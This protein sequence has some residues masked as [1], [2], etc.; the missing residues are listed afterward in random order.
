MNKRLILV[1]LALVSLS[2]SLVSQTDEKVKN[3][4]MNDK[5]RQAIFDK[6]A[7][8]Q[9]EFDLYQTKLSQVKDNKALTWSVS[10]SLKEQYLAELWQKIAVLKF[11]TIKLGGKV[12]FGGEKGNFYNIKPGFSFELLRLFNFINVSADFN[13]EM[14]K[15]D[16]STSLEVTGGGKFD[17]PEILKNIGLYGKLGLGPKFP[18]G[19]NPT[20]LV[21]YAGPGIWFNLDKN[22]KYKL[23]ID[24]LFYGA[25]N[26]IFS[27]GNTKTKHDMVMNISFSYTFPKEPKL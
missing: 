16:K 2:G 25:T 17:S 27:E 15:D 12:D 4:T 3:P 23:D 13:A 5:L 9:K 26:P 20:S 1:V 8:S 22:W 19:D 14:K 11:N 24:L 7:D 10:G 18:G 6:Y 21:Y